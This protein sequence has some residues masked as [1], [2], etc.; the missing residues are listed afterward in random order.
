MV[1]ECNELKNKSANSVE[2]GGV[3]CEKPRLDRKVLFFFYTPK[4]PSPK[5]T[6]AK[7]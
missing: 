4:P 6:N 7:L 2:K 5:K 1:R 3:K